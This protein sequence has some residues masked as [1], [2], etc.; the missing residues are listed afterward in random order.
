VI[1][2]LRK[3]V[4]SEREIRSDRPFYR[5]LQHC[6]DRTFHGHERSETGEVDV[7]IGIILAILAAP[8][9]F[10]SLALISKY[11]TFFL[12][13][14][15]YHVK[16]PVGSL[17]R[18]GEI[19]HFDPFTASLPDQY[20]FIVLSMVVAAAVALWKWDSLL[21]D[22]RD[23]GNLAHLP[24]RSRD[25]FFANLTTL[26]L[27][28]GILS[29]DI[30]AVSSVLFPLLACGSREV[31]SHTALFFTT[32]VVSVVLAA[33]FGFLGVLA[34]L[35][36]LMGA[37][38]YRAFR[39]ASICARCAILIFLVAL[40]TTSFSEPAEIEHLE[41][42]AS[43]WSRFPPPAWFAG[44]CQS[45]R[46]IREPLFRS[47]GAAAILGTFCAFLVA[48]S[49]YALSYKRS[50]LRITETVIALPAGGGAIA[51]RAF[52]LADLLLLRGSVQR[53]C[54]RFVLKTLFRSEAHSLAWIGFTA[55]GVIVGAQTVFAATSKPPALGPLPSA[56]L[57]GVPLALAYFLLLGLR[58]AFEIPAPRRANWVFRLG[59]D[60]AT[61]QCGALAK[62]VMITF[63]AP[64]LIVSLVVYSRYWNWRI[65]AV[66]T[67][68][69]STMVLLLIETLLL[70]FRKIPFT[71]NAPPFKDTSMVRFIVCLLGF[72]GFSAIVPALER[73]AFDSAFPYQ[74][75]IVILFFLWGISLYAAR[76]TQTEYE[77]RVIF[78]DITS[79][80][81]ETLD[82]T[83]RR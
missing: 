63:A 59:V 76:K 71:C 10:V 17:R 49:A 12:W 15:E 53:A 56:A 22:R 83:F 64:L 21:P 36:I 69:V 48:L 25:I 58:L 1:S 51:S 74:E 72:Y 14:R 38:P 47:L 45:L 23:Y 77:R 3:F 9:A 2:G 67:I 18:G 20:F 30:N 4:R 28:A 35:A 54:Y 19:L 37:L 27:L 46:D 81:V 13:F 60:P 78:D 32:H 79:P 40:L 29:V 33:A 34:V 6:L 43:A 24:L 62:R 52:R 80:A 61:S 50:I 5:L 41:H 70:A 7:S 16:D 42:S 73:E 11:G 68:V 26:L 44:F 31:F 65:A 57:L 75:L 55:I 39:K 82:L 66:H 8:G